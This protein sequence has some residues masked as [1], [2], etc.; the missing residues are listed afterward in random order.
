LVWIKEPVAGNYYTKD[1]YKRLINKLRLYGI[2]DP[3]QSWILAFLSDRTQ[4]VRVDGQFSEKSH[5]TS[6]VPQG[7][8]MGPLL[9]LIFINDLPF[10]IDPGT[11]CR[12]FADDCLIYRAIHSI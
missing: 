4:S 1:L 3:I 6:G 7:T 10:T 11:K 12:L 5:V 8:V 9:F 2:D